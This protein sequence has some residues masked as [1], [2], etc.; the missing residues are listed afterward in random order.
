MLPF[1]LFKTSKKMIS[2]AFPQTK[3]L[4]ALLVSPILA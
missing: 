1:P 3:I 4:Y 2:H